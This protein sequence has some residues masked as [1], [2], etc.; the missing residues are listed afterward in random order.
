MISHA[1]L[2]A[3]VLLIA[4]TGVV[5]GQQQPKAITPEAPQ[6]SA[7]VGKKPRFVIRVSGGDVEKLRFKVT[8]SRDAWTTIAYTFD[9]RDDAAGWAVTALHDQA[10]G[11][12]YVPRQPLAGGNY[13]WRVASWD[14][15]SW[16]ESPVSFRVQ[17]DDVPPGDVEGL[18]M[19][20]DPVSGCVL[21][22]W[23]PVLSDREGHPERVSRYHVYRYATKGPTHPI[24]PFEA[25]NTATVTYEDCDEVLRK[26]AVVF[27]R[28]VAEDEAGN[29]PG[30]KF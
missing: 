3:T 23:L 2:A 9:Q 22:G 13:E 30:R 11:A 15:L 5:F 12:V 6:D 4:A 18:W 16:N 1:T 10:P 29:L 28:V 27:Y 25:G 21:L 7:S 8:L 14:G 19:T 20:R 26:R 24:R 17:I